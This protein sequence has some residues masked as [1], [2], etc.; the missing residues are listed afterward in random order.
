MWSDNQRRCPNVVKSDNM[1]RGSEETQTGQKQRWVLFFDLLFL[2]L[3]GKQ[4]V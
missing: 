3:S 1:Q 4:E 2:L